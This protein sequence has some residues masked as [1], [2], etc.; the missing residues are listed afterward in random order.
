MI[1]NSHY[2]TVQDLNNS[3]KV[4]R[5]DSCFSSLKHIVYVYIHDAFKY[6]L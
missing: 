1:L 6:V 3:G 4:L 2:V 5:Q